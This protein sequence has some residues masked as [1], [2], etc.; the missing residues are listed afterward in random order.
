MGKA[1]LWLE[2]YFNNRCQRVKLLDEE[3]NQYINST[4]EQ[5]TDG[6]STR[7]NSGSTVVPNLHKRPA[8]DI[9]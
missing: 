3:T 6:G 2:S 7:F 8:Q 9:K 4:W 5:I 1:K